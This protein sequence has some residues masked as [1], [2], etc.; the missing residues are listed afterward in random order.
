[1]LWHRSGV[2]RG[3]TKPVIAMM[4]MG[5]HL[6]SLGA[7]RRLCLWKLS[8]Y[9]APQVRADTPV[10]SLCLS[11]LMHVFCVPSRSDCSLL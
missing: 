5:D 6:L 4:C 3:H 7:D 11:G 9:E 2:Y 1:M 8:S 10:P